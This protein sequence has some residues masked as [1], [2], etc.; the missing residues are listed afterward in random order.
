VNFNETKN[1]LVITVTD[2]KLPLGFTS[3]SMLM[4]FLK[5]SLISKDIKYNNLSTGQK[6]TLDIAIIFG[7][8]H[9]IIA[10]VDVNVLFLDELFS[11]LDSDLRNTMLSLL[12]D[13]LGKDKSI[14]I[15]NHAEMQDDYF[16]HKIKVIQKNKEIKSPKKR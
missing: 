2:T 4:Y 11:N 13:T 8:L 16:A 5:R 3:V 9:N 12:K 14:F 6:K 1:E 7:I 10:N 15:I